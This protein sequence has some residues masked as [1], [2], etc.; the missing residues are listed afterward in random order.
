MATS[1]TLLLS[2]GC[3]KP[4]PNTTTPIYE[5]TTTPVAQTTTT[6]VTQTTGTVYEEAYTPG[7]DTSNTN[8]YTEN[9]E[10]G[11]VI[12]TSAANQTV[13][14]N[15]GVTYPDPYATTT[16]PTYKDPYATNSQS[17][18]N[19]PATR[20]S[21][22]TTSYPAT[23][24]PATATSSQSQSGGIH[25]QIAALKDYYTAEDYKNRLSLASGQSAYIKRGAMNKVIVTGISSMSEANRLKENRFPG[26]FI[27]QGGSTGGYTPPVQP[28]YDTSSTGTYNV[29]NPYGVSSSSH[30]T[31]GNS[32][33][34]VQVGAF[35]SRGKA[36]SVA[37]SQSAQYPARVKKIGKYY[38]VI[39]TGFSSRSAAKS[40]AS[41]IG[42]F[43]VNY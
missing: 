12:T 16:T 21:S 39:L 2:S 35:G 1:A 40:Y 3:V 30:T 22:S 36:Q 42:G 15:G 11:T 13:Y 7:G 18:N 32:G 34:G 20:P 10:T 27:V 38:K 37:N 14:N 6:P 23:S 43:V 26:A 31:S 17:I 4:V 29:N 41:R 19:Y 9:Q 25:L 8:T 5:T 28:N 33:V 24:Y